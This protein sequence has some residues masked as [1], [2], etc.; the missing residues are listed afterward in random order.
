MPIS[1][2]GGVPPTTIIEMTNTAQNSNDTEKQTQ[3]LTY[4]KLKEIKINEA[5]LKL[6]VRYQIKPIGLTTEV[7]GKLYIN[8][9]PL[10]NEFSEPTGIWKQ[11]DQD[12]VAA[13]LVP[14]DLL[15]LY[16]HGDHAGDDNGVKNFRLCYDKKIT[17]FNGNDLTTDLP[18][19]FAIST[20]NQDP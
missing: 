7:F 20:T 5:L 18:L 8:G 4:V 9:A 10:G 17:H 16:I 13:T 3:S 6:R 1:N 15:Q 12:F 11:C 2:P 14:G 19:I